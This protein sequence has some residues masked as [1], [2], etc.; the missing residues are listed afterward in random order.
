MRSPGVRNAAREPNQRF[1]VISL[2]GHDTCD[3]ES[4]PS[5]AVSC[6]RYS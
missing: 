5:G 2:I 1:S 6:V 4:S 3:R